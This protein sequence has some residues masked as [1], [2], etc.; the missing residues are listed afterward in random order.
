[1]EGQQIELNFT[2]HIDVLMYLKKDIYYVRMRRA[3]GEYQDYEVLDYRNPWPEI[4]EQ[5]RRRENNQ[6]Y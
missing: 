6:D 2:T 4:H 5:D 1:M 3:S